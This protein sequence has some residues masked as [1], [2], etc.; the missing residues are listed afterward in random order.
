MK[1]LYGAPAQFNRTSYG[2]YD[3]DEEFSI[4]E[5]YLTVEE[6][7]VMDFNIV[8]LYHLKDAVLLRL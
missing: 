3:S 4:K 1:E 2:Y 6:I 8:L 5:F 7:E